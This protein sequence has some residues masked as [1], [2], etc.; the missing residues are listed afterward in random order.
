MNCGSCYYQ[1][2][3]VLVMKFWIDS[4]ADRRIQP[5]Q[6]PKMTFF[7]GRKQTNYQTAEDYINK[8]YGCINLRFIFLS[9]YRMKSLFPYK[10]RINRSLSKVAYNGSCW[11]CQDLFIGKIRHRLHD[12]KTEHFKAITSSWHASAIADH[13]TSIAHNFPCS[14][15]GWKME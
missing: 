14:S 4:K 2:D 5:P 9:A 15:L 10:H 8:F 6:S 1:T 11:D 7:R 3:T 13:V 12:R